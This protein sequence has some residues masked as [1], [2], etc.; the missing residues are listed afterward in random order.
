M[1]EVSILATKMSPFS[2]DS[3]I[4]FVNRK[5]NS[6]IRFFRVDC[7]NSAIKGTTWSMMLSLRYPHRACFSIGT[8]GSSV[9][10]IRLSPLG[11]QFRHYARL[12]DP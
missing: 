10:G 4:D 1:K 11:D 9:V 12:R 3:P 6:A 5:V 2:I 8:A 7:V